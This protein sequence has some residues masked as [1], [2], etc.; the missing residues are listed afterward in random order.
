MVQTL[1]A[2]RGEVIRC[3]AQPYPRIFLSFFLL[4]SSGVLL[5]AEA[6]ELREKARDLREKSLG[7]GR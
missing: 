2:T 1:Y 7:H 3:D 5:A 4:C 6:D